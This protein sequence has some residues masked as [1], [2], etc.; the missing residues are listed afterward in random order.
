M[1][2]L[3]VMSS[4]VSDADADALGAG[5]DGPSSSDDDDQEET[6]DGTAKKNN[7]NESL[8]ARARRLKSKM[9]DGA[10]LHILEKRAAHDT[11]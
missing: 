1:S 4:D 7:A 10:F 6:V 11:I 2:P 9:E 3:S 5:G 8:A